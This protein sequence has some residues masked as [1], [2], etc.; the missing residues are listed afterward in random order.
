MHTTQELR[1][2]K[3]ARTTLYLR[4]LRKRNTYA[5]RLRYVNFFG[6]Y[7]MR[8]SASQETETSCLSKTVEK[9]I[10]ENDRTLN[11]AAW[12]K[13]E[14]DCR[15]HVLSLKCTVCSQ[16][17]ERLMSMRNYRPACIHYYNHL[18]H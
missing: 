14:T 3:Y 11:T 9:W 16:F 7:C 17:K 1:T 12:L 15:D 8:R 6:A 13:F 5:L 2:V 18:I 4:T 10:V